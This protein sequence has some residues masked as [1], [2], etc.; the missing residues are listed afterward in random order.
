MASPDI[1][2]A[3]EALISREQASVASMQRAMPPLRPSLRS[4]SQLPFFAAFG[5]AIAARQ[6]LVAACGDWVQYAVDDKVASSL[7]DKIGIV[8]GACAAGGSWR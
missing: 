7:A 1:D 3:F 4:L 2:A 6:Q 5:A 8:F